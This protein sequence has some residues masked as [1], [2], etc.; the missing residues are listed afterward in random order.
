MTDKEILLDLLD[1]FADALPWT[2]QSLLP[3]TLC[4]QPDIEANNIGVTVWHIGRS[5]DVLKVRILQNRPYTEEVWHTHGWA[6]KTGYDPRGIGFAGW[7]TLA[8][9][10]R[11]NVALIPL[12]TVEDLLP[13]FQQAKDA[14]HSYV[15][16][17][18]V[19]TLYQPP[20]GWP[21]LSVTPYQPATAY[22]CIRNILL[23]TREHL[24]EIKALKAMWERK[25]AP[26]FA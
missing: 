4:W 3:A 18:A 17:M 14:L 24:G 9:F 22:V 11:A 6:T 23:D 1:N 26:Q 15:V 8:R 10:T 2:I 12:L 20:A 5:F 13:Y 19:D 7:G 16:A 21:A 25:V